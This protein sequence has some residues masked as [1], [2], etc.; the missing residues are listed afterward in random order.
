M[1]IL[2][3]LVTALYWPGIAGAATTP[4]WGLLAIVLPLLLLGRPKQEITAGHILGFLFLAWSAVS[5]L[6][7]PNK[8]DGLYECA[9]LIIL[10]QAFCM[11]CSVNLRS[12]VGGMA[13]GLLPSTV[14]LM[15]EPWYPDLVYRTTTHA[16]LFINSGSLGE[17]SALVLIGLV[18]GLG[19][20]ADESG[21]PQDRADS[22]LSRIWLHVRHRPLTALLIVGIL[23]CVIIPQSRGSWLALIAAF[24]LW[25]WSKSKLAAI[26]LVVAA[27]ILFTYSLHIAFHISSVTQRI[28]LWS[29][30]ISGLTWLG[31]GI[32]SL[33]TDY[34]P[35]SNT[36]D[37]FK[38]RPEHIHNDWLEIVFEGGVIGAAL[39][40]GFVAIVIRASGVE[41]AILVGFGA[42]AL[43]GFPLHVPATAFLAALALGSL[44]GGRSSI[45]DVR[46]DGGIYVHA[47]HDGDNGRRAKRHKSKKERGMVPA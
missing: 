24:T 33:W 36:L 37:I 16:G 22:L 45:R 28:G 26:G 40:V 46:D 12:C 41:R 11:G 10:A 19:T 43:V 17:I 18:Y 5:V 13:V 27:L 6:W 20:E 31:H 25:L 47:G 9:K 23:P 29:D 7:T 4:R 39:L 44:V 3:F 32:G 8:L 38:E 1:P 34:A 30:A 21:K 42:E 35:L 15:I 2:G 14:L